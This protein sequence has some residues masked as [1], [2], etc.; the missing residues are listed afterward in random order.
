VVQAFV[1][2]LADEP[3]ATRADAAASFAFR[4]V[5]SD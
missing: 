4:T 5:R 1:T 3:H 2:Q